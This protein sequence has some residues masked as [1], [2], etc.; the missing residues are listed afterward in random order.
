MNCLLWS[1]SVIVNWKDVFDG[2]PAEQRDS[3]SALTLD[4]HETDP[5]T[6]V[7]TPHTRY[8]GPFTLQPFL[9]CWVGILSP[10]LQKMNIERNSRTRSSSSSIPN[11]RLLFGSMINSRPSLKIIGRK[12]VS[13]ASLG[14]FP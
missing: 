6:K 2:A 8:Q 10:S 1:H 12:Q 3:M 14:S 4:S 11:D 9:R 13:E 7:D 5:L